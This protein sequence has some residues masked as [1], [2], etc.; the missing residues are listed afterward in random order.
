MVD[1]EITT[2]VEEGVAVATAS[3]VSAGSRGT[4]DGTGVIS[5]G[6]VEGRSSGTSVG[7]E[8]ASFC[9]SFATGSFVLGGT[10]LAAASVV[11]TDA[12][13]VGEGGDSLAGAGSGSLG[14]TVGSEPQARS[15][16]TATSNGTR[17]RHN[18]FKSDSRSF[19][20]QMT[21]RRHSRYPVSDAA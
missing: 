2:G 1:R 19:R 7:F 21:G 17:R 18:C 16:A 12:A 4:A 11:L 9:S 6:V 14:D 20:P 5:V 8:T 10:G 3:G 13:G 15:T